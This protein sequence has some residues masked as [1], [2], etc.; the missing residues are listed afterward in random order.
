MI[1][2]FSGTIAAWIDED[3]HLNERLIDF[4]HLR[5]NEHSGKGG[6]KALFESISRM[7]GVKK[8][9]RQS[10]QYKLAADLLGNLYMSAVALDNVSS[11]DV[12]C[13]TLATLMEKQHN[14]VFKPE[15]AQI[16]CLAHVVN[17]V[18]QKILKA[19]NEVEADPDTADYYKLFLK[20]LPMHFTLEEDE[21]LQI[22]EGESTEE[23]GDSECA[24]AESSEDELDLDQI[25]NE[26]TALE[27]V[28]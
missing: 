4:R 9:S 25:I 13:R 24:E 26:M 11:N 5:N 6:A 22:W 8:I 14:L 12:L 7:G 19:A 2:T 16:H 21:D 23:K 15:N 20:H 3:W 27:K 18:V 17:L 28:S 10:T 1:F